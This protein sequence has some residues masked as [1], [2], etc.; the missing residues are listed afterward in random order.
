VDPTALISRCRSAAAGRRCD[1][2]KR[3]SSSL[4]TQ[5]LRG[6]G[7]LPAVRAGPAAP[8]APGSASSRC[9][10]NARAGVARPGESG[11]ALADGAIVTPAAADPLS[12]FRDLFE[13]ASS[14]EEGDPTAVALATVSPAGAPSVRMVLLKGVDHNGFVFYT[15]DL[16]RKSSELRA[17]PRAAL[18]FHWPAIEVQV[19]VEG[20]V[21]RVGE[22]AADAYFGTRPRGS[23]LAAWASD[24]SQP[25]ASREELLARYR[26]VE[27]RLGDVA[28]PRP[29]DWHGYRLVPQQMEFWHA[30]PNRL[31][32]R[33]VFRRAAD[34]WK[35]ELLFP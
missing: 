27:R 18:C 10:I 33:R 12:I 22:E 11:L 32:H 35:S 9:L 6:R 14:T 25:L 21:E 29:P 16:S 1:R 5:G 24:Q 17:N 3:G 30:G 15:S 2:E 28:V 19:R 31:H 13:R 23:Q 4:L 26:D 34:G 20:R 8:K 7:A